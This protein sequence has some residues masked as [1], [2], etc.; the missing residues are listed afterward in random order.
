MKLTIKATNEVAYYELASQPE[1]QTA[2]A[3]Y[4]DSYSKRKP[5]RDVPTKNMLKALRM[6]PWLNTADD[7]ARLHVTE[8]F[9]NL[10]TE[11]S[12]W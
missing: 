6:A 10:R 11:I 5:C 1:Y 4:V 7:W 9:L 2:F 8:A 3:R 12:A